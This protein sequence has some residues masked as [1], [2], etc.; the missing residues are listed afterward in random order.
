MTNAEKFEEVFGFMPAI[1]Q[2][3]RG[4]GNCFSDC[5]GYKRNNCP[6]WWWLSEYK[7]NK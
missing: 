6:S 4:D 1:E 2:C 3:P 7:E 5:N